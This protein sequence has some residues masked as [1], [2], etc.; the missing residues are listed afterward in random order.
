MLTGLHMA[1]VDGDIPFRN[2]LAKML[3]DLGYTVHCA[4]TGAQVPELLHSA[5]PEILFLG[6]GLDAQELL[7]KIRFAAPGCKVIVLADGDDVSAVHR[8][9]ELGAFDYLCKPLDVDAL[10]IRLREIAALPVEEEREKLAFEIMIPIQHYTCVQASCTIREG[11]EQLKRAS[12]NFVSLGLMMEVGHRA[13]LVFDGEEMVG[14]LTMRNLIQAIR[15]GYITAP[16][17]LPP[18]SM[19]HSPVFWAG[20]FTS[21]VKELEAKCVAEI[22]NPRPPVVHC[23]ANLM[24]V[25]QLLCEENRR[26]V[27]VEQDGKAIGVIRE[28]ELFAQISRQLLG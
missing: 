3:T 17:G 2:H 18:R 28:Q 11:I 21:Q 15:P 26:R 10:A 5:A 22:M 7:P 8:A 20:V 6:A 13:V 24:Q 23:R 9:W 1:I 19:R 27:V 16:S 14:V 4:D 12:E 25:A